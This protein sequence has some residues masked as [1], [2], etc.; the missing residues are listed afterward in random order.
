MNESFSFAFESYL[1]GRRFHR[2]ASLLG[3]EP[4][5]R[6]M[7][8]ALFAYCFLLFAR[9]SPVQTRN[10]THST[11]SPGDASQLAREV[12]DHEIAAQLHDESLW[13][14]RQLKEEKGKK[15]LFDVCQTKEG[16]IS[17]LWQVNGAPL[18][19]KQEQEELDRIR[20]L[21]IHPEAMREERK[22]QQ[23][24]ADKARKLM[25][26]FPDA[27]LFH[28]EGEEGNL[29]KLSF[30]PNP[31]YNPPGR[32]AEVFHHM[33]GSLLVDVKQK[34]LAEINGTLATSVKFG[35]GL[36]GH[37]DKG[38]TFVVRQKD[39]GSGT[40]ELEMLN[41]NMNGKALFFKTIAVHQRE[42]DSDFQPLPADLA[43]Q[44]AAQMLA[45]DRDKQ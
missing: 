35:G 28:K 34:R 2:V 44:R 19:G 10:D 26:I 14:Y 20:K 27:F 13:H 22:K 45:Q 1:T 16:E 5:V 11:N 36:L 15:K 30:K 43:V 18:S 31:N 37:L 33:E 6:S 32:E 39:L 8:W 25:R 40:W 17:R 42:T 3:T 41:V 23:E 21:A 12:I 9:P 38:G 7:K 29:T 24:D 4:S